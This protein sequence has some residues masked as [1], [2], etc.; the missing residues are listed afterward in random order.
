[1]KM[2]ILEPCRMDILTLVRIGTGRIHKPRFW[3]GIGWDVIFS[4]FFRDFSG[5]QNNFFSFHSEAFIQYD[6]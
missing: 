3:D 1:M 4:G 5:L 2:Q 6:V